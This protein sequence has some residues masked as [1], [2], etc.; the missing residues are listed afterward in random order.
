MLSFCA[1]NQRSCA[2]FAGRLMIMLGLRTRGRVNREC[3]VSDRA[4]SAA[5]CI[6]LDFSG[7]FPYFLSIFSAEKNI[8]TC[9][10]F[11]KHFRIFSVLLSQS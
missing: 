1:C 10:Y 9:T 8:I 6:V 2:C 7:S 11:L 3:R 5:A 4:G